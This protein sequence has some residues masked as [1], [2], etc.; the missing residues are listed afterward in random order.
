MKSW[1]DLGDEEVFDDAELDNSKEPVI[2]MDC[3]RCT[4]SNAASISWQEVAALLS[5]KPVQGYRKVP[6]GFVVVVMCPKCTATYK[7][8]GRPFQQKDVVIVRTIPQQLLYSWF[9]Q[10]KAAGIF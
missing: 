5:G 3:P 4:Y 10:G 9:A 6:G 8:M 7:E 2:H 1:K